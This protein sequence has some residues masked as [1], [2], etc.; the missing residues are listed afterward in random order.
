MAMSDETI[1]PG[2][3]GSV[4]TVKASVRFF[5]IHDWTWLR[6]HAYGTLMVLS[7]VLGSYD[8]V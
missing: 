8:L 6:G 1:L 2:L 3:K 7:Q 5:S 4:P